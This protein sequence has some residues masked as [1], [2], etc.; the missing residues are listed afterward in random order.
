MADAPVDQIDEEGFW[1][2]SAEDA[3]NAIQAFENLRR[4]IQIDLDNATCNVIFYA[5]R[6]R[7][8]EDRFRRIVMSEELGN[9]IKENF[10]TSLRQLLAQALDDDDGLRPYGFEGHI[11]GTVTYMPVN[12][13]AVIN[14]YHANLPADNWELVF[15]PDEE[16]GAKLKSIFISIN[17]MNPD[18]RLLIVQATRA[19]KVLRKG[20]SARFVDGRYEKLRAQ[21]T[22]SLTTDID[23]V[24]WRG[25]VFMARLSPPTLFR[26]LASADAA[27]TSATNETFPT[28][29]SSMAMTMVRRHSICLSI[30]RSEVAQD[31]AVLISPRRM[32]F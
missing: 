28:P 7:R 29:T 17:F 9:E 5:K 11:E 2:P 1:Q 31:W 27:I 18:D 30:R 24:I 22:L 26:H 15:N 23:F 10:D 19:N 12:A 8:I 6:G 25:F 4:R 14:D 3:A 16:F 13:F 32:A 21:D 20:I